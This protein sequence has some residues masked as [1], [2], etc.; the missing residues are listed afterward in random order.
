MTLL[1]LSGVGFA[2]NDHAILQDVNLTVEADDYL[3]IT[4][5]SGGGK[6]TLLKLIATMI[7]P[8]AGAIRY[9]GKDLETYDPIMYRRE[10]SYCFQQPTLF[11][12]DV[13]EN[14]S[15]PALIR[16]K[17]FDRNRAMELMDYVKLQPD[18]LNHPVNELSGGERQRVALIR[19]LMYLPKLLLLDEISTGLDSENK[20]IVWSLID[21]LKADSGVTLISVTHDEREIADAKNLARVEDGHL[22]V[23]R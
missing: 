13:L 4:G 10:V 21:R 5:P 16:G 6:S 2:V 20:A 22:E 15:F 1:E 7:S 14:L 12:A 3:T 8:T 9:E 11:G 17:E 18:M 23:V 19:N